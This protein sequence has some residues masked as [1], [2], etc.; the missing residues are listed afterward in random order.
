LQSQH[1]DES[2]VAE[3]L[4]QLLIELGLI[5]PDGTLAPDLDKSEKE[6]ESI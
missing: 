2:G 5:H 6:R 1:N 3:S 4:H